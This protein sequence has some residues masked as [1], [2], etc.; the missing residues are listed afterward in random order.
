MTK[1]TRC[2]SFCAALIFCSFAQWLVHSP[3][4]AC[5]EPSGCLKDCGLQVW[6]G[7]EEPWLWLVYTLIDFTHATLPTL[8]LARQTMC[9]IKSGLA[10]ELSGEGWFAPVH[11]FWF[12]AAPDPVQFRVS[13]GRLASDGL[14]KR[15]SPGATEY[16]WQAAR[17]LWAATPA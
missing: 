1:T 3:A 6:F 4:K 15:T 9:R 10:R 7:W 17:G 14:T 13:A 2:R 8:A 16:H 5:S 11:C 12:N